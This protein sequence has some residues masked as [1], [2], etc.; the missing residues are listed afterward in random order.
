MFIISK[1][2]GVQMDEARLF[3]VQQQDKKNSLNFYVGISIIIC[4]ITFLW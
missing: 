2:G 1:G 4:G 3:L